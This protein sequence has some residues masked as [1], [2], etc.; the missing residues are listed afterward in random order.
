MKVASGLAVEIFET[1]ASASATFDHIE[2]ETA[3]F[4]DGAFLGSVGQEG[5][6]GGGLDFD[7][8]VGVGRKLCD[9]VFA[10]KSEDAS[11]G[12][13]FGE[14]DGAG[15]VGAESVVAGF[16]PEQAGEYEPVGLQVVDALSF[17]FVE[18]LLVGG[19]D[20]VVAAGGG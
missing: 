7:D 1:N 17:P 15:G 10:L 3:H 11:V 12:G 2:T 19:I 6:G 8:G 18:G 20:G 5:R 13:A 4:D 16:E 14:D 9:Y